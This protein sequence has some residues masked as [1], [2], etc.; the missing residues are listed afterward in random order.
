MT[1]TPLDE[2]IA[3]FILGMIGAAL[4]AWALARAARARLDAQ[5][6]AFEQ[7][8]EQAQRDL[9][10]ALLCVPQWVQQTVRIELELVS[11]QQAG[12]SREQLLEQQRWQ[13]EQDERRVAE[14]Q[15]LL[16]PRVPLRR[17]LQPPPVPRTEQPA[18][19]YAPRRAPMAAPPERAPEPLATPQ[20]APVATPEASKTAEMPER[21]LTDEEIDA[22]PP[23]L[24]VPVASQRKK[25]PA[26]KKPVLRNI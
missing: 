8:R 11:R 26:P 6:Q 4:G 14:W 15:A 22:L 23:D 3:V 20:P 7:A 25:L 10:Q 19:V 2:L 18:P 17:E 12:R 13:A 9:H 21:E 1:Q 16:S 5:Q 24:P